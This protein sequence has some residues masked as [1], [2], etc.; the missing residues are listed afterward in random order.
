VQQ[1][2]INLLSNALKFSKPNDSIGVEILEP[3]LLEGSNYRV[4]FVVTDQGM[5]LNDEDRANLF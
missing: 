5:G 1:I 4:Q 3:T 2:L